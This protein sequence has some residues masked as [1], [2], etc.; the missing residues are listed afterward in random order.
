VLKRLMESDMKTVLIIILFFSF[1]VINSQKKIDSKYYKDIWQYN[2]TIEKKAK[3]IECTEFENDSVKRKT[4]TNIKTQ[5]LIWEKR[6]LKEEP[7]GIWTFND[8]EGKFSYNLDYNF[9]LKYGQSQPPGF[10]EVDILQKRLKESIDGSFEMPEYGE[11]NKTE[12]GYWFIKQL[13]Y[14][15]IAQENGIQGTVFVQFTI[16]SN[17]VIGNIS[18]LRGVHESIDRE[19]FRVIHLIKRVKPARL[20]GQNIPLYIK[21]PINYKLQ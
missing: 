17:G 12:I 2:E 3:Y 9:K 15:I 14:P 1:N 19:A 6:F 18:V 7:Y 8:E 4:F 5:K 11:S 13:R 10:Y 16:D 20:D 21:C